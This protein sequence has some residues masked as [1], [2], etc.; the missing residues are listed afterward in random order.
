MLDVS[1][2]MFHHWKHDPVTLQLFKTF[3]RIREDIL[4][5]MV[6]P[7]NIRHSDSAGMLREMLGEL[8]TVD[9]L[10]LLDYEGLITFEEEDQ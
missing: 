9:L 8:E 4:K 10:L 3:A 6:D 5:D 1:Q 2:E 7:A